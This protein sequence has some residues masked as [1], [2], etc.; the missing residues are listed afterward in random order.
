MS[1]SDGREGGIHRF[2][3]SPRFHM[4]GAVVILGSRSVAVGEMMI[5]PFGSST[6]SLLRRPME[7]D[8]GPAQAAR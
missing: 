7:R 1:L 4:D 8:V 3:P 6:P 2:Q 5:S